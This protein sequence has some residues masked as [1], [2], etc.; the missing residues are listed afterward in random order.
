M[1]GKMSEDTKRAPR[2][3][4][5]PRSVCG[6]HVSYSE[7]NPITSRPAS[8]L[9][10]ENAPYPLF[11]ASKSNPGVELS[12]GRAKSVSRFKSDKLF[13]KF[14]DGPGTART[15]QEHKGQNLVKK[16]YP[17]KG[18]VNQ[19]KIGQD[20]EISPPKIVIRGPAVN[21]FSTDDSHIADTKARELHYA[22]ISKRICTPPSSKE[23]VQRKSR[24]DGFLSESRGNVRS[25]DELVR[26]SSIK[27]VSSYP[28]DDLATPM[29]GALI[30][31]KSIPSPSLKKFEGIRKKVIEVASSDRETSAHV[32]DHALEV[33]PSPS[34]RSKPKATAWMTDSPDNDAPPPSP[35]RMSAVAVNQHLMTHG[36]DNGLANPLFLSHAVDTR[37]KPRV[38]NRA[39]QSQVAKDGIFSRV[40]SQ[41]TPSSEPKIV[42]PSSTTPTK[43]SASYNI[44]HHT[45]SASSV[46]RSPRSAS[47]TRYAA[48]PLATSSSSLFGWGGTFE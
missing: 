11:T 33:K 46:Q 36:S 19:L 6:S 38:I 42:I 17:D 22:A 34:P 44:L 2:S 5:V 15:P 7:Y 4:S 45:P 8:A 12:R 21:I 48:T 18:N 16:M 37:G 43:S 29:G 26:R 30:V 14:D 25:T 28:H 41:P 39:P 20:I 9:T 23:Y 32:L 3:Q 31:D 10:A 24:K 1:F 13:H 40:P 35:R 47:S 27:A